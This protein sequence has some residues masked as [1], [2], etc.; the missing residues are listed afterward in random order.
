MESSADDIR[1]V[2]MS[3][4]AIQK[5]GLPFSL[6]L[7]VILSLSAFSSDSFFKTTFARLPTS[8][9]TLLS[10]VQSEFNALVQL[11]PSAAAPQPSNSGDASP[12]VTHL[13]RLQALLVVLENLTHSHPPNQQRLLAATL[14]TPAD[15]GR[16]VPS[17]PVSFSQLYFAMLQWFAA[18]V[19]EKHEQGSADSGDN[20]EVDGQSADRSSAGSGKK[21]VSKKAS[22]FL[23]ESDLR[24]MEQAA[25]NDHTAAL[26]SSIPTDT[27]IVLLLCRL[28]V[29]LTNKSPR[30]IQILYH[31][32]PATSLPTTNT[33]HSPNKT[34]VQI[35]ADIVGLCWYHPH[36]RQLGAADA[37]SSGGGVVRLNAES[38][39]LDL[40]T[41]SIGVMINTAEHSPVIREVLLENCHM[42]VRRQL[43]VGLAS[44]GASS[45]AVLGLSS[46]SHVSGAEVMQVS[47]LECLVDVFVHTFATIRQIEAQHSK[48]TASATA[49]KAAS[50]PTPSPTASSSV[51]GVA[52]PQR[53]GSRAHSTPIIAAA[54]VADSEAADQ[55]DSLVN[56]MLCSY[57]AMVLAILATH[58]SAAFKLVQAA[59]R[60]RRENEQ[61]S[62]RL[63][64]TPKPT[65]SSSEHDLLYDASPP[66]Q[67]GSGRMSP[68]LG[69]GGGGGGTGQQQ[70]QVVFGLRLVVRLLNDF[71]VLQHES[72]M[73]E[74]SV[75]SMLAL[76][77][78]LERSIKQ[79]ST[80][81]R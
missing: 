22:V 79:D 5:R 48:Q 55:H 50:S 12:V 62:H 60:G 30:G 41:L 59:L 75:D 20:M 8:F 70:Q 46:L 6:S 13:F 9:S 32:Y 26:L 21:R 23:D 40:L 78:K 49:S 80:F 11:L 72:V 33:S 42:T 69:G 16:S 37:V 38:E 76:I 74:E 2:F 57:A 81:G 53:Y 14:Q 66:P 10:C 45:A 56:R 1:T 36:V 29:N 3:D 77:A 63:S 39:L 28:L 65:I 51:S 19:M 27:S 67:T 64:P 68:M 7:F 54:P 15:S 31:S 24:S 44:M 25:R 17:A 58:D 71:L 73:S 4:A 52:A 61:V 43:S 47:Y 18:R 34:G 35:M